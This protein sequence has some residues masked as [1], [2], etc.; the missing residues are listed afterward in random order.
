VAT[1]ALLARRLA[2]PQRAIGAAQ[3]L[4]ARFRRR[5]RAARFATG[6][7]PSVAVLPG[8]PIDPVTVPG[9][10]DLRAGS[11]GGALLRLLRRPTSRACVRGAVG[12]LLVRALG[13]EPIQVSP[14]GGPAA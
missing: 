4:A 12:A 7:I 1:I 8:C 14:R 10:V 5:R 13:I 2:S 6:G 9:A 3:L 11:T